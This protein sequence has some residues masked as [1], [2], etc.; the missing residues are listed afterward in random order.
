MKLRPCL[1][2]FLLSCLPLAA[3]ANMSAFS[4]GNA[5][6]GT[7]IATDSKL[8]PVDEHPSVSIQRED[9][10]ITLYPS[11]AA[12]DLTYRMHNDG[13]SVTVD[14]GFPSVAATHEPFAEKAKA[15]PGTALKGAPADLQNY[16]ITLN[17]KEV[18]W[19]LY[20]MGQEPTS[21]VGSQPTDG[22]PNDKQWLVSKLTFP[23][24]GD[25]TV[26]ITYRSPYK[27][28]RYYISDDGQI[29]DTT[30]TYLLSTGRNWHGPIHEGHVEIECAGVAANHL[31]LKP[32]KRFKKAG[33][34]FVWEFTDLKPT[35]DDDIRVVTDPAHEE[36]RG[37]T[38]YPDRWYFNEAPCTAKASSELVEGER[39][40]AARFAVIKEVP[41][42]WAEGVEG[43]GIG[44]SLTLTLKKPSR[45]DG[46]FINNGYIMEK[47]LFKENNRVA[48]FEVQV[49]KH[50]PF[51]TS[52]PD[53][54][55]TV[56]IPFPDGAMQAHEVKLTIA[57]VHRG[58]KFHDTCV[59]HVALRQ[60]LSAKPEVGHAR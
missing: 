31:G 55:D 50:E 41:L 8:R 46:F 39:K 7:L 4:E 25:A 3:R 13:R 37:Y 44:E 22:A 40:F 11:Y 9:L 15:T 30:F 5:S 47:Q 34:S 1:L 17:G 33:R 57:A 35:T 56:F 24:Q 29:S 19:H 18:P 27:A 38:L 32:E 42:P 51:T 59:S 26:H 23:G 2:P 58:S 45:I 10:H 21:A 52:I 12:V 53:T 14:T 48:K 49:D 43:D 20:A 36:R 60:V 28:Y 16:H 6:T 54:G